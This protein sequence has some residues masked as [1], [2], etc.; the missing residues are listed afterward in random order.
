MEATSATRKKSTP[1]SVRRSVD[2]KILRFS[3]VIG[4]LVTF[5]S[6]VLVVAST[7]P[8]IQDAQN[9][10]RRTMADIKCTEG[11]CDSSVLT[12][13]WE[14]SDADY[15]VDTQ[16]GYVISVPSSVIGDA[17]RYSPLDYSDTAFI[18]KFRLPITY[19]APNGEVWRLYSRAVTAGGKR[20]EVIVGYAEKAAWKMID[21]PKS[22]MSLVD[23]RLKLETDKISAT[24]ENQKSDFHGVRADGFEVVDADSEKVV[25]WGPWLPIYLPK[26]FRVPPPGWKPY[27]Y[28]GDLYFVQ[29]DA[30]GRLSA[31]SL[32]FVG[33][34]WWLAILA[35]FAFLASSAVARVIARRFLRTYFALR[36]LQ[37]PTLH[38]ALHGGEGQHVE[39][40]R[41]LADNDSKVRKSDDELAETVAAFAN[42]N[43]GVILVGVD[44]HGHIKGLS[45]SPKQKDLFE[46]R[47]RQVVRNR[48]NPM[49]PIQVTFEEMNGLIVAKIAV[50]RG[51]A[52]AY[53]MSG[54]IYVRSGSTDVQ[55]Q[56]EDLKRLVMEY[57]H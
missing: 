1:F 51:D 4:V 20:Y 18:A 23:T 48:I 29:T 37:V 32:I 47:V 42:T 11:G 30:N 3:L 31:I 54:V 52:Q 57:G 45:L 46:Q 13:D 17:D 43:D 25:A 35:G 24:L 7:Y 16:T 6:M 5:L 36:G 27:V 26:G 2:R 49:P 19:A 15:V 33:R 10:N 53:M 50:A 56:P 34:L 14:L 12:T 44:D 28:N 9:I 21:S 39:F 40:K 55:A 38:Q 41:A 22:L 8:A